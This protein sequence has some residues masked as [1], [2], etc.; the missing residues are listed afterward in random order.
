M[1]RSEKHFL[2]DKVLG[3]VCVCELII[4]NVQVCHGLFRSGLYG[5]H[6]VEYPSTYSLTY[7]KLLLLPGPSVDTFIP[8]YQNLLVQ[9]KKFHTIR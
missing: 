3:E 4:Q 1:P 2:A 9:N 7:S 5:G 8:H 6:Q